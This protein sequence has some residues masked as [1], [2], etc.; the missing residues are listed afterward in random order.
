MMDR[1]PK[2]SNGSKIRDSFSV[3]I[4]HSPFFFERSM[5]VVTILNNKE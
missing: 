2:P 5:M 4:P 1:E 3:L